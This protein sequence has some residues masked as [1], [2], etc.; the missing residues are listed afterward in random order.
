M[1]TFDQ[2]VVWITGAS[3]GIGEEAAVQLSRLGARLILSAR[4]EDALRKVAKRCREGSDI[5]ILQYDVTDV[6][7]AEEMV[8]LVIEKFGRIDLVF[9]SAG[10]SQRSY[11]L[12]TKFSVYRK[13]M[14][15]NYF[16]VVALTQA[17]L[18]Q[19]VK[20]GGGHILAISSVVGKFGFGARSAYSASKHAVHGYLESVYLELHS[21]GIRTTLIC[22][23]PIRTELSKAA[24][25][26]NGNPTGEMD[27]MQ[28]K[29]MSPEA[30]V[31]EILSALK[32]NE[33]ERVVGGFPEK[34]GVKIH[35]ISPAL[36]LKMAAKQDP[37]GEVK[38]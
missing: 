17:A 30:C 11:A 12:E 35:G 37:R 5:L 10:I 6:E 25:D 14:E 20:Q 8:E 31:A 28:V 32:N 4:R 29:G 33:R 1:R 13:I 34:L 2:K 27:E 3:S 22:A 36:F 16:G 38:L 26:A 21:Q 18:P 24:L 15:V 9:Q 7:Q 23:G 19:M